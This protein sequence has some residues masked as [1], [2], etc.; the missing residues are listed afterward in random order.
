MR[1]GGSLYEGGPKRKGPL[2]RVVV[3]IS[4][5]YGTN[6]FGS[7]TVLLECGHISKSYG[8]KRAIC[9]NCREG[10]PMDLQ[11]VYGFNVAETIAR[12]KAANKDLMT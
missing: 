11:N 10:K 4:G 9:E 12:W 6:L 5:D 2:R 7:D 3:R 8:G 1:R